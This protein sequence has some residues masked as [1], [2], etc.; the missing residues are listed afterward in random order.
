VGYGDMVPLA[1][2]ARLLVIL[3][4]IAGLFYMAVLLARL[5][6]MYSRGKAPCEDDVFSKAEEPFGN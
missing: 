4:S 1:K 6:A 5:V 2:I 3:E